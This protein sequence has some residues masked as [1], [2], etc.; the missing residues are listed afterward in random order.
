MNEI[1]VGKVISV[2]NEVLEC[3]ITKEQMDVNLSKF[4]MDSIAFIRIVVSLEE[5]FNCEIPDSNLIISEMD[6]MRKMCDVLTGV[7]QGMTDELDCV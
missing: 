1:I 2:L 7:I 4:S 5:L 3:E 6:T